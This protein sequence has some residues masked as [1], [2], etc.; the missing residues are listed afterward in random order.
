MC[1]KICD[2]MCQYKSIRFIN[3]KNKKLACVYY[4]LLVTVLGYVIGY[5]IIAEKGYQ[6]HDEDA[7]TTGV[8]LKGSASIGNDTDFTD[9]ST[10]T[11]LDAMD[12]VR[13]SMEENA[14]FATTNTRLL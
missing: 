10:L 14:F 4:T 8:T 1:Q 6:A 9:I 11:P 5:T 2:S 3:V 12:L 7:D 13:P